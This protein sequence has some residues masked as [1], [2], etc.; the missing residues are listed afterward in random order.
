MGKF[1]DAIKD[2]E[3]TSGADPH[4]HEELL[5]NMASVYEALGEVDKALTTY[6]KMIS[7][8]NKSDGKRYA[9]VLH[10]RAALYSVCNMHEYIL[11]DLDELVRL[12]PNDV[13]ARHQRGST[14]C[15]KYSGINIAS[16]KEE[17]VQGVIFLRRALEDFQAV[18]Q[19][20]PDHVQARLRR[21]EV[22]N[23]LNEILEDDESFDENMKL[24]E[25]EKME[26]VESDLVVDYAL[27]MAADVQSD[28]KGRGEKIFTLLL[29]R[30]GRKN[31]QNHA[32]WEEF[33]FRVFRNG[34]CE[35]MSEIFYLVSSTCS[36]ENFGNGLF[37]FRMTFSAHSRTG[38]FILASAR[39]RGRD[40]VFRYWHRFRLQL[41]SVSAA[42]IWWKANLHETIIAQRPAFGP[43]GNLCNPNSPSRESFQRRQQEA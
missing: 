8:M 34:R 29:L 23:V 5:S 43:E 39:S 12:N 26:Q 16:S 28:E 30:G 9:S 25:L 14:L 33:P 3:S 20:K 1:H 10:R 35:I 22:C 17:D 36:R 19:L 18:L 40:D 6:G 24:I 38:V 32:S 11:K 13:K 27:K 15:A 31:A 21:K 37:C 2:F 41:W 4:N 42:V 7:S